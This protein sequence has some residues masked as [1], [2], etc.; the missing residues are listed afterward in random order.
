MHPHHYT[1]EA[2]LG[3]R[4]FAYVPRRS[5]ALAGN[6]LSDGAVVLYA[7]IAALGDE[8]GGAGA[9][10]AEL[11]RYI[12]VSRRSIHDWT[13][14]LAAVEGVTL[15]EYSGYRTIFDLGMDRRE[16][17][18]S[19]PF[20][21]VPLLDWEASDGWTMPMR[22]LWIAIWAHCGNGRGCFVGVERLS[23]NTGRNPRATQTTLGYL[24][25]A[26]L[27][28]IHYK[29]R[30]SSDLLPFD[31]EQYLP[32]AER[33]PRKETA[34]QESNLGSK[35]YEPRKQTVETSEVNRIE[36]RKQTTPYL[37]LE[38]ESN[39][40]REHAAA[41]RRRRPAAPKPRHLREPGR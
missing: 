15:Y 20:A 35:P 9:S 26:G 7:T 19:G 30:S 28:Q 40:R 38:Q 27:L 6:S 13:K 8:E 39:K 10:P 11:S 41:M 5:V 37:E 33:K 17:I 12:G 3:S 34:D 4:P 22:R 29:R 25:D 23:K 21:R 24:R 32:P 36:P 31:G 1:L 2:V 18:A 14:A 16:L